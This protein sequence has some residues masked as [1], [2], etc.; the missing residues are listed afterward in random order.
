MLID[1]LRKFI[2]E[3]ANY[4][5]QFST[6]SV[7]MMFVS[8]AQSG[9]LSIGDQAPAF[10][11]YDQHNR[12]HAL[13]DYLG[14]WVVLYFYPRDDTPGCT[15]QACAFRDDFRQLKEMRVVVLGISLDSIGSHQAFADKH[16]LPF[17]LLSDGRGETAA[18]YGALWKLGPIRFARRHSFIID[19]Q[20]RMR[21]IFRS[22]KPERNSDEIIAELVRL[23]AGEVPSND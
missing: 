15:A 6:G 18:A 21:G 9:G 17:P 3:V 19:P 14:S 13:P 7:L 1:S 8:A 12:Q 11:L 20:G 5:W 4:V 16:G 22:V 23:G 2:F 10:T